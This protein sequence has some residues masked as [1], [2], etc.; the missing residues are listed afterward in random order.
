MPQ[1]TNDAARGV[2]V[3]GV[4]CESRKTRH[5]LA[6]PARVAHNT[7]TTLAS[8]DLPMERQSIVNSKQGDHCMARSLG[9]VIADSLG[10]S[11]GYA[12][13]L[14]KD[15]TPA[16][17]ARYA[18]IG[19]KTIE[20]N[21][22]AFVYGHLS[23]YGPRMFTQLG[24]PGPSVPAGFEAVFSK[25]AKCVDDPTGTVYPPMEAVTSAFFSGY[26]AALEL[27][28]TTPDDAFQKPNPMEGRMLELFPTLGSLHTFYSGGH[29][30]MHL[31][32]VSA[33]RRMMGLGA[34]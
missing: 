21:H 30:M 22:P 18:S 17:F 34:A 6:S 3:R 7:G 23:I 5:S 4:R 16:H 33:W 11:L 19:G 10:L 28:R 20:S 26:K 27:L 15:V 31:G 32:Q 9:N 24:Q 14:L 2:E 1:Q 13:R 25:D 12:E 29:I 8:N